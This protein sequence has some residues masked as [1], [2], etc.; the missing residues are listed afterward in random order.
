MSIDKKFSSDPLG[1]Y[2]VLNL[3]PDADGREI[4]L[5]YREMAKKWHPDHNPSP[6]AMEIFQKISAAYDILSDEHNR[7]VY[8]LAARSHPAENFPDIFSLKILTDVSGQ[9]NVFVRC[10]SLF[11]L[12]GKIFKYTLKKNQYICNYKEAE[13]IVFKNSFLNCLLGWWSPGALVKNFSVLKNN[14]A[15][16]GTNRQ[17]NFCLLVHNALAYEQEHLSTQASLSARQAWEYADDEAKI[18]LEKFIKALPGTAQQLP[19]GWNYDRLRRLQL[20]APTVLG[21]ILCAFFLSIGAGYFLS[22]LPRVPEK[23]DY[24][25]EVLHLGGQE[26]FDDVV[27]AKIIDIRT[28]SNSRN[29][30]YHVKDRLQAK[31]MYGPSDHF[32][33]LTRLESGTTVRVTGIS[34]DKTWFR[35]TLDNGDMGFVHANVLEEGMGIPVPP[36]SQVYTGE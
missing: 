35:I 10:L 27:V 7:L 20:L 13:K 24:Y 30:L 16:T 6:E 3:S 12:R 25:R 15:G 29:M 19:A 31:V 23:I 21:G 34:P 4:K 9:N 8:D 28:D 22:R 1:Y 2:A 11:S 32:D 36:G 33:I 17:D 18:F 5:H 14:Y 26:S